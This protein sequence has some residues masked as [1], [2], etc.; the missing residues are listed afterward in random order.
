MYLNYLLQ[1]LIQHVSL[2]DALKNYSLSI[3]E[4][5]KMRTR[6][7]THASS[8]EDEISSNWVEDLTEAEE[9]YSSPT[10]GRVCLLFLNNK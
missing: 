2:S 1:A 8:L 6:L 10:I 9:V 4:I 3:E 7:K 5:L